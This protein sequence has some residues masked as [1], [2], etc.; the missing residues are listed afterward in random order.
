MDDQ[1]LREHIFGLPQEEE[2][3]AKLLINNSNYLGR[4]LSTD[5]RVPGR[6]GN[7]E[8]YD[9]WKNELKASDFILDTVKNGYKFPFKEAPPPSFT[10]NNKSFF[11]NRTFAYEELLRLES[12]GCISRVS[13]RPF[14]TLPL[15]VVFSKKFSLVV[16]ASRHL[17]PYLEDRKVKLEDLNVSEQLMMQGDY[18]TTADLDSGYWYVRLNE[19]CKKFVGVHFVLDSG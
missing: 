2:G 14:I 13:E 19:E 4:K 11:E 5:S 15:S 16:D 3:V 9:F 17:N 7:P 10:K 12:L 18:Q 8:F 6:I 1:D